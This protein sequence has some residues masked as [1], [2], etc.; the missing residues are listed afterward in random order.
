MSKVLKLWLVWRDP[1]RSTWD[2]FDEMVVI[3]ADEAEA[4]LM[5]PKFPEYQRGDGGWFLNGETEWG[6]DST[7]DEPD[8]LSIEELG[9][10]KEDSEVGVVLASYRAG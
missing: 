3:A 4:K 8:M 10:A 1:K 5:H 7:W 6:R 9:T 2:Q